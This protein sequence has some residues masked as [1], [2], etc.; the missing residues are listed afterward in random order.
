MKNLLQEIKSGNH[1]QFICNKDAQIVCRCGHSAVQVSNGYV[2][3]TITAYPCKYNKPS[4]SVM[5]ENI[6]MRVGVYEPFACLA[7]KEETWVWLED[8]SDDEEYAELDS[9]LLYLNG[10]VGIEELPE[11]LR[12]MNNEE[13]RN[14]YNR[15][16]P[17]MFGKAIQKIGKELEYGKIQMEIIF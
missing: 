12:T 15:R 13:L 7:E 10:D 16:F 14:E 11:K 2:C 9:I 6:A 4:L 3:G 17:T 1:P 8:Y 5:N